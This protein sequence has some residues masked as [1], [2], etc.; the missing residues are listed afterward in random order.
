MLV[1]DMRFLRLPNE[2]NAKITPVTEMELVFKGV[3]LR[4]KETKRRQTNKLGI[5]INQIEQLGFQH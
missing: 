4:I 5:F 2:Q 1:K 3:N